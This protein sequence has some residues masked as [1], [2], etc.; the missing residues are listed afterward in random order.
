MEY[1]I[2]VTIMATILILRHSSNIKRLRE[3]TETI[4][5]FSKEAKGNN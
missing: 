1:A 3:G 4:N 2:V 5:P